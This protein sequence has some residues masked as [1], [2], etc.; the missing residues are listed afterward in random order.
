MAVKEANDANKYMTRYLAKEKSESTTKREREREQLHRPPRSLAYRSDR[1]S[2][3]SRRSRSLELETKS[4]AEPLIAIDRE[5]EWTREER[6]PR[7]LAQ[8]LTSLASAL[9]P[10]LSLLLPLSILF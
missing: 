3:R 9:P 5:P 6:S 4:E 2:P 7:G 1:D 8:N 10:S